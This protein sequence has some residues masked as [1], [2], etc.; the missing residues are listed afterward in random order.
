[1]SQSELLIRVV[2]VLETCGIEY[3]VT[4]SVASSLHGQPRSTHDIDLVV[5]M[6]DTDIPSLTQA[7]P[8]PEFYLSEGAMRDAIQQRSTFNLLSM[9]DGDKVDFWL[10]TDAPFDQ[11]RFSRRTEEEYRGVRLRVPTPEDTILAKLAWAKQS[12]GSE[13]QFSDAVGVYEVHR[14]TLDEAYLDV[15]AQSLDV[16]PMLARL[17]AE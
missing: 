14:A 1:M 12:G 15:W 17:R 3:M 9:K 5:R 8:A 13:K 11:S 16:L 4:G 7:F 6:V 2:R 10:L